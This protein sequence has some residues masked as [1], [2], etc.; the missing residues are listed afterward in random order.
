MR[1]F[2]FIY[3]LTFSCFTAGNCY[4]Q[5]YHTSSN[6]ALKLYK[7]GLHSYDFLDYKSA[8]DYFKQAIAIDNK[9]YEVYRDKV[10]KMTKGEIDSV[11]VEMVGGTD[12]MKCHY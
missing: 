10:E 3:L 8:E 9:F 5:K 2:F 12:C 1:Q 11:T 7:D 4:C 6:R